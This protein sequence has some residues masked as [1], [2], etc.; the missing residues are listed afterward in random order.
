DQAGH[1]GVLGPTGL[2]ASASPTELSIGNTVVIPVSASTRHTGG[3][4]LANLTEPLC[5]WTR[6]RAWTSTLIPEQSK[7]LTC[8]KSM[9]RW[10]KPRSTSSPRTAWSCGQVAKSTSPPTWIVARSPWRWTE[11]LRSI[12]AAVPAGRLAAR[13]LIES[14]RGG[15]GWPKPRSRAPWSCTHRGATGDTPS[16]TYFLRWT[17]A[18]CAMKF[19]LSNE[20][21]EEQCG[22]VARNFV[23]QCSLD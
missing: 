1:D 15:R 10:W 8:S 22:E 2:V 4:G 19:S 12:T 21:R 6:R 13:R 3:V 18:R 20:P 9:I 11:R 23:A 16:T 17:L 14:Q 5:S 7:K